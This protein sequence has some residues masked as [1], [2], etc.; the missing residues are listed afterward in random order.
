MQLDGQAVVN[1]CYDLQSLSDSQEVRRLV[2][3]LATKQVQSYVTT[4]CNVA[5]LVCANSPS[6]ELALCSASQTRFEIFFATCQPYR[7]HVL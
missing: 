2:D 5:Y 7:I 6:L 4:T 3:A 1:A